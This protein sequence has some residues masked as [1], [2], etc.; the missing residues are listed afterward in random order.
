MCPSEKVRKIVL[1]NKIIYS[2]RFVIKGIG[3]TKQQAKIRGGT[4]FKN[5]LEKKGFNF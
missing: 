3:N 4:D 1:N 2:D 5:K